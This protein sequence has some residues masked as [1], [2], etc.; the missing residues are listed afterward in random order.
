MSL[1]ILLN[2]LCSILLTFNVFSQIS[3]THSDYSGYGVS[4]NGESDGSIDITVT[5]GHQLVF[6]SNGATTED[7]SGLP[8]GLY[9]AYV[10]N[11]ASIQVELTETPSMEISATF[12]EMLGDIDI[13]VTGGTAIY[14]YE[15]SN[16]ETTEDLSGLGA[17]TYSVVGTY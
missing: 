2:C 4:C 5:G 13:T 3:E 10:S 1:R 16:G 11:G 14:T 15:W 12:N 17:G 8:A 7:L 6:W 9:T